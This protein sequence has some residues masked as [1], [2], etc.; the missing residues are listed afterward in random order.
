MR[1]PLFV[2]FLSLLFLRL[3]FCIA[4]SVSYPFFSVS[5]I[6]LL[7]TFPSPRYFFYFSLFLPCGRP[8]L[9]GTPSCPLAS[10][11]TLRPLPAPVAPVARKLG[12][13]ELVSRR[14]VGVDGGGLA[15][16]GVADGFS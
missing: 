14:P 5:S 4:L 2:P 3:L 8:F 12:L 7:L 6:F 13:G 1:I 16:G 11:F 10:L 15:G 9:L